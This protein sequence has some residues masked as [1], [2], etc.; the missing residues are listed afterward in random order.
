MSNKSIQSAIIQNTITICTTAYIYPN[1][2]FASLYFV[3]YD[4][5]L[6]VIRVE[7]PPDMYTFIY[8]AIEKDSLPAS[9]WITR[10]K[11]QNGTHKV[12]LQQT[13]A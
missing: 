3:I 10:G 11:F 4:P 5:Y 1:S 12:K 6:E 9:A 8:W 7:L 13:K 2:S